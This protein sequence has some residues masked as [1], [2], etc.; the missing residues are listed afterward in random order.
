MSQT[1]TRTRAISMRIFLSF[2]GAYFVS[3]ALR[4]VNAALA[5]LLAADLAQNIVELLAEG[6]W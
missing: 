5:P 4:S 3:Y 1:A 6:A 2:A